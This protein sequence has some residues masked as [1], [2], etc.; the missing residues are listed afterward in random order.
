LAY[1]VEFTES[2]A[3][4]CRRLPRKKLDQIEATIREEIAVSPQTAGYKLI[5][6]LEGYF[7]I[8]VAEYRIV[9]K[10][11]PTEKKV[12]IY[13]IRHRKDVYR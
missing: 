7:S 5:G 1:K 10:I 12:L 13:R 8:H 2:A 6:E 11:V 9:Y 4:D 3:K